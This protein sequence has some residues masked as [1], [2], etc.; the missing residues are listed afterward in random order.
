MPKAPRQSTPSEHQ[1]SLVEQDWVAKH[2]DAIRFHSKSPE[3]G[4]LSNFHGC[5]LLGPHGL[6]FHSVEAFF[7]AHKYIGR[8]DA[9][10]LMARFA[11]PDVS[12]NKA[13]NMG[14]RRGIP[15]TDA[16]VR[17]WFAGRRVQVMREAL[18]LKFAAGGELAQQLIDTGD[19]VLIEKLPI[20]ADG[21]WGVKKAGG[22]NML[23]QLIMEVRAG[24][25]VQQNR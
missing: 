3:H 22:V 6:V 7:Q 25:V 4:W 9:K 20:F 15:M 1:L 13:K 19:K 23:G 2:P 24:L 17:A 21:F 11:G 5:E 16:E 10:T 14:G 8:S 12:P 18:E